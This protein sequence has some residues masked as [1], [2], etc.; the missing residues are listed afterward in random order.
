MTLLTANIF[1]YVTASDKGGWGVPVCNATTS[2]SYNPKDCKK[3]LKAFFTN[4][5][6]VY[7]SHNG[8]VEGSAY[9]DFDKKHYNTCTVG[10]GNNVNGCQAHRE[11]FLKGGYK[12]P[13]A[14]LH[15]LLKTCAPKQ[16]CGSVSLLPDPSLHQP[17]LRC[18]WVIEV[19]QNQS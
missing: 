6:G 10:I 4:S 16:Q 3:A 15:G 11:Y 8:N 14:S 12:H 9:L 5:S 18:R 13:N 17:G 19:V 2:C 7:T 1:A